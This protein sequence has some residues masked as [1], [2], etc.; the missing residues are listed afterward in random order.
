MN[1]LEVNDLSDLRTYPGLGL[2]RLH[3][4]CVHV[5]SVQGVRGRSSHPRGSS[6]A[7]ARGPHR[8]GGAL[9]CSA[10]R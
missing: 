5:A 4:A 10:R 2:A 9:V 1:R 6:G 7:H 8:M 3:I